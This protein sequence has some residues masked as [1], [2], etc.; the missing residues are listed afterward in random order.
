MIEFIKKE[1]IDGAYCKNIRQYLC[2]KLN[3]PQDLKNITD[4][5]VEVG[6]TVY[7]EYKT[8]SPHYHMTCSEYQYII[9]GCTKYLDCDTNEEYEF[10]EGDFFIIRPGT[11]Y[12]QKSQKGCKILFVKYPSGNDKVVTNITEQQ[13]NWGDDYYV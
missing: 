5:N 13:K 12:F 3:N 2:G 1:K 11:R 9:A 8:E 4:D 6:L 7:T 10:K